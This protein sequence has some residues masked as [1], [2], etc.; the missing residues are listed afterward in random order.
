VVRLSEEAHVPIRLGGLTFPRPAQHDLRRTPY[1]PITVCW[2]D[3]QELAAEL[4]AADV[5]CGRKAENWVV[6]LAAAELFTTSGAGLKDRR[7]PF[8]PVRPPDRAAWLG[9]DH[10]DHAVMRSPVATRPAIG[11]VLHR[12]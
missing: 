3:L 5:R 1:G 8:G 9:Q 12:H 6:R 11:G 2:R 7:A 4:D 10:A